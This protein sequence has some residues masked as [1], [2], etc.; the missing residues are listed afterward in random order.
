MFSHLS[1]YITFRTRLLLGFCSILVLMTV[2]INVSLIQL[3]KLQQQSLQQNTS[4]QQA[5]TLAQ[6]AFSILQ[7]KQFL[8][9]AALSNDR[10]AYQDADAAAAKVKSSIVQFKDIEPPS[11]D[12]LKLLETL[13]SDFAAFY[14]Q[15]KQMS[16]AF[17]TGGVAAGNVIKTDVDKK[18]LLLTEQIQNLTHKVLNPQSQEDELAHI[19]QAPKTL[20]VVSSLIC[21]FG[22]G[23]AVYLSRYL[24]NQLGIDPYY[25]KGI[26]KELSRGDL[27]RSIQVN[28]GDSKSLLYALEQMRQQ[29]LNRK[30]QDQKTL[31]DILR[32]KFALD[33]VS[34]GVMITDAE[35]RIIYANDQLKSIFANAEHD[36]TQLIPD[37]SLASLIGTSLDD[38]KFIPAS[39]ELCE[40]LTGTHK[41]PISLGGHHMVIVITP[42]INEQG[43]RLGSVS[44]W[45]DH[46][47]E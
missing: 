42:V 25:A 13:E 10:K 44:E 46:T 28:P 43:E 2:V 11:A 14:A 22:L 4:Q 47:E 26:A 19:Q 21:L 23:I 34:V 36:I 8:S 3:A 29:L 7:V 45:H 9:D 24:N 12:T 41:I 1:S 38:L 15:A 18:S 17:V 5:L 35:H 39:H 6:T 20:L 33:T 40:S 30:V 37:F 31:K 16:T 32:V 27:S